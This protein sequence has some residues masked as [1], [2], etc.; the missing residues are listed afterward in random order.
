MA[1]RKFY[2]KKKKREMKQIKKK[3][4]KKDFKLQVQIKM[5]KINIT[6]KNTEKLK[7]SRNAN[8]KIWDQI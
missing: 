1:K 3:K 5:Q 8:S 6:K 4:R 2:N 7:K